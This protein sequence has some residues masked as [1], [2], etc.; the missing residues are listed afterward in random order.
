VQGGV[1]LCDG[2]QITTEPDNAKRQL[3]IDQT[4]ILLVNRDPELRSALREALDTAGFARVTEA[5]DG[6]AAIQHLNNGTIDALV[7]DIPLGTLDGWRLARLVRSGVFP[8]PADIP[9]LVVSRSYSEHIAEVTAK[10]Y[11]INRFFTFEQRHQL[12]HAL[13]DAQ[14]RRAAAA[15]VAA[16]DRG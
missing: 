15:P 14:R 7:T 10:E 11:E 5:N 6:V 13:R 16:G 9:I 4:H 3:M 1:E 12:P 2:V 8:C